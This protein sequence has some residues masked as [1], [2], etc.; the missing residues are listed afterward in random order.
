M[1]LDRSSSLRISHLHDLKGNNSVLRSGIAT[2]LGIL[3][4][5]LWF[6][7]Y[8][9]K[10]GRNNSRQDIGYLEQVDELNNQDKGESS[11]TLVSITELPISDNKNGRV[12]AAI[13]EAVSHLLLFCERKP[14]WMEKPDKLI[15]NARSKV[16][17]GDM[18]SDSY[19]FL[20]IMIGAG[21]K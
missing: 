8:R 14:E 11:A 21:R 16:A 4:A 19:V 9:K 1:E 2:R 12:I 3:M 17:S 13:I 6:Q 15:R 7:H 5:F 20:E 18:H 10:Y